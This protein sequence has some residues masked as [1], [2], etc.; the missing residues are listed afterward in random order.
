MWRLHPKSIVGPETPRSYG[1]TGWGIFIMTL[2][3]PALGLHPMDVRSVIM[4][5]FLFVH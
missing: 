1:F 5:Q 2:Q 4:A 3:R